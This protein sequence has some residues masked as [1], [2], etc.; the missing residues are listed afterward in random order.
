[1]KDEPARQPASRLL[2]QARARLESDRADALRIAREALAAA[3]DDRDASTAAHVLNFLS[4]AERMAGDMPEATRLAEQAL[5][6]A[7]AA[8]DN[9]AEAAALNN[10]GALAWHRGEFDL[11]IDR[12]SAALALREKLGDDRG[13]ASTCGN[14]SLL[15]TEKGDLAKAMEYQQRC[16]ALREKLGDHTGLG[17]AHLNLGVLHADLGDWDKALESYFRA[18]AEQERAGDTAHV[19]LCHNNIGEIYLCRGK[20]DR[21]RFHLEQALRLVESVPAKWIQA[22]VLGTLGA[23]AFA[24]GDFGRAQVMYERDLTI[25]RETEEREEL[26]ETLRRVAELSLA[27]G[28][29]TE[30]RQQLDEALGLAMQ[31]GLRREEGSIRRVLGELLAATG[32]SAAAREALTLA[33]TILRSVGRN[34]ELGAALLGRARLLGEPDAATEAQAIFEN[35]GVTGKASEAR[36]LAGPAAGGHAPDTRIQAGFL[37]ELAGLACRNLAQDDFAGHALELVRRGLALKGVVAFM[38]DGRV[39]RSGESGPGGAG[40][41]LALEA[42]GRRLGTM[43]LRGSVDLGLSKTVADLFALGLAQAGARPAAGTQAAERMVQR[44]G[45]FPAIIGSDTT[46]KDVFDTAER[47]GPT[48]ASVLVLGESGTGKELVARAIHESSDRKDKPFTAVNCA[49]IPE[50]LL[51]SELFGVEK[52]TATGVAARIGRFEH[53]DRG[54][55]FL[56]EIGDMS[57]ALQA[58]MLRVL[59]EQSFDRVGGRSPVHVDVR[60]IAAT[61]R[62]LEDA[63][64]DGRFRQDLLYRLNVIMITLPPLRERRAD[65]PALVAHFVQ[66]VSREYGKPLRG[67]SDDCLGVLMN[68]QWPGNVRELENVVERGVILARSDLVTIDDLPPYMQPESVPD[69]GW[70]ETRRKVETAAGAPVEESTVVRAL[71]QSGWVVKRAAEKLGISRRQLHRIMNKHG[72]IKPR[73]DQP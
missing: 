21:A 61:N 50:T 2:D 43:M 19:A 29:T 26:A 18:L 14:I 48:R 10:L 20:L 44:P 5:E 49:A 33:V 39:Y 71:E 64:A 1:M 51:E 6:S 66:R 24:A 16:L 25:C 37:A 67:V 11:A 15:Y 65:I 32:D 9:K 56:D 23:V 54:T 41:S 8:R 35:L 38:R 73:S 27:R 42:G 57:L 58:K 72:I 45:R 53:A 3:R 12:T 63:I 17:V 31:C 34:Y 36:V 60:I 68:A 40:S 52:G 28:A 47:V 70:R 4:D 13:V 30:A 46:L 55:M 69:K 22:E 59:E 62:N 7:R